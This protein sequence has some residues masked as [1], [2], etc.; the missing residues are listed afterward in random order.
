MSPLDHRRLH[1]SALDSAP[2]QSFF[3]ALKAG[4]AHHRTSTTRGQARRDLFA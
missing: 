1:G 4:L 3:N 2:M